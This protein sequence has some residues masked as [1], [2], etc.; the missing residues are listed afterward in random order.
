MYG[1]CCASSFIE[2]LPVGFFGVVESNWDKIR[3]IVV[4]F[5]GLIVTLLL[6]FSTLIWLAT[7]DPGENPCP[8]CR[9]ISCV[10]FPLFQEEKW[11]YCDKCDFVSARRYENNDGLYERIDLTCPD[12]SVESIDISADMIYIAQELEKKLPTYCRDFCVDIF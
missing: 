3:K 12:E 4:R 5:G 10:P 6:I 7:S 9:Y 8:G 2:A 11:W 1:C